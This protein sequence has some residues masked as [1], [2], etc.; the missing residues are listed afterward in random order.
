MSIARRNPK[1][2]PLLSQK[3]AAMPGQSLLLSFTNR[4]GD[5]YYLHRGTTKTGKPRYFAA[6]EV[7]A[8]ALT[9]MPA[10]YEWSESV[11][12]VVS[13][14]LASSAPGLI[15]QAAVESAR[16]ELSRHVHLRRHIVDR[17]RNELVVYEP[18]GILTA[19]ELQVMQETY[20]WR[21]AS[22]ETALA[23]MPMKARYAPVMKFVACV[24]VPQEYLVY[25]RFYRGE[26]GWLLL[27]SGPLQKLLQQFVAAIGT[28]HFFE[29]Y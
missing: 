6:K 21:M 10:G 15:S 17:R 13:V 7:G 12:G 18:L 1:H 19:K 25:R 9:E 11:N 29:L 4:H 8:G 22:L 26:G 14:R 3:P 23:A 24:E 27:S 20:G 5:T 2:T 28:D 16:K